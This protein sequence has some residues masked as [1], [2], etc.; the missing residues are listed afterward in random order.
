MTYLPAHQGQLNKGTPVPGATKGSLDCGPRS[1]GMAIDAATR[2]QLKLTVAQVRGRMGVPGPQPSNVDDA[3]R[4]VE[5]V[6][7][8]RYYRLRTVAKLR[9]AVA[10]SRPVHLC[11]DYGT[12]NR[13]AGRTGDPRF[14]GGHSVLVLGQR[15][16]DGAVWW[17]L[18]DP[19]DDARRAGIPQGWRWVRRQ[20][21]L[22][23]A[24]DFGGGQAVLAGAVGGHYR[25]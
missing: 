12:F 9:Q 6:Q 1:V 18:F 13:L 21:L 7:G 15:K 23:A 4:G 17:R 22:Q 25:D 10:S 11:I 3:K 24:L 16:H 14:A 19:L 5:S 8:L 2:G 20:H